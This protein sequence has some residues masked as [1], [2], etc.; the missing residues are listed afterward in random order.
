MFFLNS[1]QGMDFKIAQLIILS[2]L[3]LSKLKYRND[4]TPLQVGEILVTGHDQNLVE[5]LFSE[6]QIGE[7]FLYKGSIDKQRFNKDLFKKHGRLNKQL[8]KEGFQ[9]S[10]HL[11]IFCP[12]LMQ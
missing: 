6:T 3:N 10:R 9:L 8:Q 1:L 12:R 4:T 11:T 5:V 2:T 7:M